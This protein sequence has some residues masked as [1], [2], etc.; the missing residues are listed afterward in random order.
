LPQEETRPKDPPLQVSKEPKIVEVIRKKK[1]KIKQKNYTAIFF[2]KHRISQHVHRGRAQL[3]TL[4]AE[5]GNQV[6]QIRVGKHQTFSKSRKAN[7]AN[8]AHQ[9]QPQMSVLRTGDGV[10]QRVQGSQFAQLDSNLAIR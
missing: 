7:V 1:K 4:A 10:E 3:D 9:L 5:D 6:G 8:R 2:L